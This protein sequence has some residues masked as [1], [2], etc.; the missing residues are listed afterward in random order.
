M[1][2]GGNLLFSVRA[3]YKRGM[4]HTVLRRIILAGLFLVPF[5]PLLRFD[6]FFF[7]FITSKAFAFRIIVEIIFAAW[8]VLAARDLAVRPRKSLIL[9]AVGAFLGI[10]ALAD[11]FGENP[12]R[13]FWSNYER[14]EG[15][16]SLVHLAGYF[17]VLVSIVKT[18]KLWNRLFHASLGVSFFLSVFGL[19]QHL[20]VF[21]INQGN[22]RV[23]ATFG[24]AIY[25]AVFLLF[26]IFITAIAFLKV[27][28]QDNQNLIFWAMGAAH[29]VLLY[30]AF[31]FPGEA[32]NGLVRTWLALVAL[33]AAFIA[34]F[35]KNTIRLAQVFY[36]ELFVLQMAALYFTATRGAILGLII[37]AF[38]SALALGYFSPGRVRKIS[39]SIVGTI[40]VL[41]AG[42]IA[43]KDTSFV[44]DSPVLRRFSSFNETT[45]VSR[46][47]YI[48]PGALEG[49]KERPILGWGQENYN[50]V[51]N[52]FYNPALYAQEQWFDRAHNVFLDWL[53]SAGIL[54]LL[55]YLSLFGTALFVLIH[56]KKSDFSLLERALI[57]G[58][59]LGYFAQNVTV[60]DNLNSYILFFTFL[61]YIHVRGE[62]FLKTEALFARVQLS[63]QHQKVFGGV[64]A[65]LFVVVL[66]GIN[67][68][69]IWAS[70]TLIGSLQP[71][72]GSPEQNLLLM[73]KAVELGGPGLAEAREQI[74]VFAVQVLNAAEAS[75]AFKEEVAAFAR[76]QMLAQVAAAPTDARYR[77]F[78]GTL[79]ARMGDIPGA[80]EQL[81]AGIALSPSKQFLIFELGSLYMRL[82]DY[83]AALAQFKRAYDLDPTFPEAVKTYA[84]AALYSGDEKLAR[85][86]AE[87]L[88]GTIAVD[89]D[90]FLR[91]F[92]EKKQYVRVVELW[93]NRVAKNPEN[94]AFHAGLGS[95]YFLN[96]QTA[97]ALVEFRAAVKIE[98]GLEAQIEQ[99]TKLDI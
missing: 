78:A 46:F 55:A 11:T 94:G 27:R 4:I 59:L 74:A 35:Y 64:V 7:P 2:L 24:N 44:L 37:G 54:G 8:L 16:V 32:S 40:V 26:H 1:S 90:R 92:V 88:F 5:I 18:E 96:K 28:E 81:L 82:G 41:V 56:P 80:E 29:A 43:V 38:A 84:L 93:Q 85:T 83:S 20:G 50:V 9:F 70:T 34:L 31:F 57:S 49:F 25:F 77:Y 98:P 17:L 95:A 10:V 65:A 48:W 91:F 51:F 6:N 68:V 58:L 66:Y 52:K 39:F 14:M 61:A 36:A 87:P 63:L 62:G 53:I 67:I 60:F 89:D 72:P 13:S 33:N 47:S 86:L 73:R 15:F 12:L 19:L 23:D 21:L 75:P 69:P 99:E 79:F 30:S 45:I 3:C 76:E 22:V 42:F 97:K 71:Q